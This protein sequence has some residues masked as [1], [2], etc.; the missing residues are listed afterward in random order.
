MKF[1]PE[2]AVAIRQSLGMG[3]AE[4]A[5]AI[6]LSR[7]GLHN[8]EVGDSVP[9]VDTLARMATAYGRGVGD[10]FVAAPAEAATL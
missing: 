9:S 10:F 4:A 3:P 1:S 5:R 7:Q 6:G 2:L 8:I